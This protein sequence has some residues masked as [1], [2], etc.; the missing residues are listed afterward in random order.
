MRAIGSCVVWVSVLVGSIAAAFSIGFALGLS[1]SSQVGPVIA[2]VLALFAPWAALR[3]S[4][5]SG[6]ELTPLKS[7]ALA[8]YFVSLVPGMASGI[9]AR[10]HDSFS[11]TLEQQVKE[12]RAV[13]DA[14]SAKDIVMRSRFGLATKAGAANQNKE[15]GSV[16]FDYGQS[17]CEAILSG[18][19]AGL[20]ELTSKMMQS[21]D[22]SA[23]AE[24]LTAVPP[25]A[26]DAVPKV[27]E[28]VQ[29]LCRER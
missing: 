17:D 22:W 15:L 10:T 19:Y 3:T 1:A 25:S 21:T 20:S 12:L 9:Y 8:L 11:P 28:V 18:R 7:L 6:P 16:L 27:L 24:I 29:R 4:E 13:F 14:R 5:P 23:A 2:G 26:A